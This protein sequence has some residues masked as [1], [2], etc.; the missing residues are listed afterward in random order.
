MWITDQGVGKVDD[1]RGPFQLSDSTVVILEP[2]LPW[3]RT[4]GCHSCLPCGSAGKPHRPFLTHQGILKALQSQETSSRNNC[5]I[6]T[7]LK[8]HETYLYNYLMHSST[9]PKCHGWI[10]LCQTSHILPVLTSTVQCKLAGSGV[11]GGDCTL[12]KHWLINCSWSICAESLKENKSTRTCKQSIKDIST[13]SYLLHGKIFVTQVSLVLQ[14]L[15]WIQKDNST[16]VN[17]ICAS[18][19]HSSF[20]LIFG[21]TMAQLE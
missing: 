17:R 11:S 8:V 10:H 5:I 13:D 3:V 6:K 2:V 1:P 15:F 14:H 12:R 4:A 7:C 20:G 18:G 16:A 21:N 9:H 19:V